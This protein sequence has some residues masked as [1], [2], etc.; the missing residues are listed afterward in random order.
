MEVL[1]RFKQNKKNMIEFIFGIMIVYT[2]ILFLCGFFERDVLLGIKC[3][4]SFI[5][6]RHYYSAIVLDW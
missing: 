4:F 1:A 2:V 6:L 5:A 3:F